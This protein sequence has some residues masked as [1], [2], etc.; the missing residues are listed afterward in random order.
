MLKRKHY[1]AVILIVVVVVVLF[2]LPGQ[3]LGKLKL[4][5]TGLFL[6]AMSTAGAARDLSDKAGNTLTTRSGLLKQNEQLRRENTD[7]KFQLQQ[8]AAIANENARLTQLLGL[9]WRYPG[10]RKAARVIARDPA[11]WWRSV[12][13]DVGNRDGVSNNAPVLTVEGLVGRVSVA[14]DTRSQVILLGD[15]TLRVAAMVENKETGIIMTSSSNPQDD[16]MVD[17]GY[18]AG[19][20]QVRPGQTVTTWGEGK[21]F[22]YGI[23]IGKIVDSKKNDNGLTVEARVRLFAN[24]SALEE[25]WVMEPDGTGPAPANPAPNLPAPSTR[26]RTTTKKK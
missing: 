11:N 23:P 5:I 9:P 10:K 25:V 26:P 4:A 22:P 2:K 12:Q 14:G 1:I 18:L 15:P 6:P 21:I 8:S 17:L 16:N 24:I 7:L 13:I 3:T 19:N 20:S